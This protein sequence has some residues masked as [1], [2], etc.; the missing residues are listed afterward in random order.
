MSAQLNIRGN[1]IELEEQITYNFQVGDIADFSAIKSNYTSSFKIPK[2]QDVVR[3]FEGLGISSDMSRFP[4]TIT[5]VQCLDDYTIVYEG[6]LI[7]LR[8]DSLYYHSTV[9][10]GVHDL[11]S[12]LGDATLYDAGVRLI[13]KTV[14]SVFF[15]ARLLTPI[16]PDTFFFLPPFVAER[17][18][19]NEPGVYRANVDV[20]VQAFKLEYIIDLIFQMANF[21]YSF[22]STVDLENEVLTVPS[23]PLL[24]SAIVD[25][26]GLW[27]A[28]TNVSTS[29]YA[30]NETLGLIWGWIDIQNI[31]FIESGQNGFQCQASG[32]YVFIFEY[33]QAS[34]SL[35]SGLPFFTPY[36]GFKPCRVELRVNDEVIGAFNGDLVDTDTGSEK[37]RTIMSLSVGDIV[38]L[39]IERPDGMDDKFITYTRGLTSFKI[40]TLAI[41]EAKERDAL[42]FRL[43]QFIKEICYR[44]FLTPLQTGNHVEFVSIYDIMNEWD[45]LDWS[46][47]YINRQEEEYTAGYATNNWLRHRYVSGGD[48]SFDLNLTTG[49]HNA[50]MSKDMIVSEIFAPSE[51]ANKILDF[52]VFE[53]EVKDNGE[54]KYKTNNRFFFAHADLRFRSSTTCFAS[55]T[56]PGELCSPDAYYLIPEYTAA[57]SDSDRWRSLERIIQGLRVHKIDLHI[58]TV[59]VAQL[60]ITR[61]YYFEQEQAYYM[62]N[63]LAYTKGKVT[64]AEFVKISCVWGWEGINPYCTLD[65]DG[66]NTG[67]GGY[68]DL[69]N[70]LTGEEKPNVPSD[71]DYIAPE[72][73]PECDAPVLVSQLAVVSNDSPYTLTIEGGGQK[74]R[75]T[76]YIPQQ[77]GGRLIP[78][79]YEGTDGTHTYNW[80]NEFY[81]GNKNIEYYGGREN[82]TRMEFNG[83]SLSGLNLSGFTNLTHVQLGISSTSAVNSAL[84]DLDAGGAQ[85]GY[86]SYSGNP[87][88]NA[89][90]AYNSLITKGWTIDGNPPS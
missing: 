79:T 19:I 11:G 73:K 26:R 61:I 28:T 67:V 7:I 88:S 87:D 18:E 12:V 74:Y 65:N 46:G 41:D 76:L 31:Y 69:R 50:A 83:L 53:V 72:N 4:Y 56:I 68:S 9:I 86:L 34:A 30:P 82:V 6:S 43:S 77:G 58:T 54:T 55:N 80:A 44:Y 1:I 2:T 21:T 62:L 20:L 16:I 5:D 14:E 49:N 90:V 40:Y 24:E 51:N 15:N 75:V 23:P 35:N 57:F 59:D 84:E 42:S 81:P 85:D 89:A 39:S 32:D 22:P 38:T 60:D 17:N 27:A 47:K 45:V 3:L 25:F 66:F 10:S 70:Y 78:D 13:P 8:T 48:E 52:E 37:Y 36:G 71:P 29:N 33:F 64:N 63:R